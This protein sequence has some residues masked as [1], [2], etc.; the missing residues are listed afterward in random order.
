MNTGVV[1]MR[2][3]KALLSYAKEQ[4]AENAI[5]GNMLQLLHTLQSVK[6]LQTMLAS[7]S[8]TAA[9]RLSLLCSAVDSSPVY[10]NFMRLVIKEER[11]ALL[12]FIAHCYISLYRKDKNIVAVTL[13][14]AV[15]ANDTLKEKVASMIGHGAE[16]EMLNVVDPAIIGGFICET[17]SRRLDA[18]VKRQLRDINEHLIKQNRKLV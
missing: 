6:E 11:E 2:Y 13:T 7:P 16:V 15:P 17:D 1:S 9:Q 18:S 12:I 14:T 10:E 5:Y 3:A 8:V 4:G